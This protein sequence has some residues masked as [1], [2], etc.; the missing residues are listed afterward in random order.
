MS[1]YLLVDIGSTFTKLCVVDAS[2]QKILAQSA[3]PTTV[4]TDVNLGFEAA[5]EKLKIPLSSLT[6]TLACSSAAGGLRIIAA[7]L[8]PQLTMNAAQQAALGAGGKV[9]QT[10]AYE[11]TAEDIKSINLLKPDMILLSGGTDGG[12]RL[13]IIKNARQLQ[14]HLPDIPLIVAGNRAAYGELRKIFAGR[15]TPD[16]S[17]PDENLQNT[18]AEVIFT[19]NVLPELNRMCL[20]PARAAIRS[21]FLKRIVYARGL[22]R[23][24]ENAQILMP[25]PEAV[26][27]AVRLLSE[28]ISP[29][30]PGLG[31]LLA[32]DMGGATTDVYS[33][34]KGAPQ[35]TQTI[36]KGLPEPF[37]KRTVEADIGMRHTPHYLLELDE[38]WFFANQTKLEPD[39]LKSWVAKARKQPDILP[40]TESE[41]AAD[42]ILSRA[43][44][45]IAASRHAGHLEE[46]FTP[47]GR[48]FLQSG[49]DLADVCCVLGSGGPLINSARPA[50]ILTAIRRQ[51]GKPALLPKNPAYY[52][53]AHYILW[54]MGLLAEVEPSVALTI[55]KSGLQQI[56]D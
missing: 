13:H 14:K 17:S 53:D 31:E 38:F 16:T 54:A 12:D 21:L 15:T 35:S 43:G 6:A 20:E 25:T 56:K 28:G 33:C 46:T 18:S 30:E 5:R 40:T 37:V 23:L 1:K 50:E 4:T 36:L 47:A 27:R 45:Y 8:V 41:L 11:L 19:D 22:N 51:T 10:F 55:L 52:L 44:C 42:T 26:L 2:E 29:S 49:K 7:G 24:E 39:Q 48:I 34:A 3:A 32:V 9:I